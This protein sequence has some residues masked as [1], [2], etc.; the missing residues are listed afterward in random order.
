VRKG[1]RLYWLLLAAPE[2]NL[3]GGWEVDGDEIV[4]AG[5]HFQ[6]GG[7]LR[8]LSWSGLLAGLDGDEAEIVNERIVRCRRDW[9]R[10]KN[11]RM[12]DARPFQRLPSRP[13]K[14]FSQEQWR[15]EQ[16]VVCIGRSDEPLAG[17][18]RRTRS[19]AVFHYS[20]KRDT[21]E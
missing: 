9:K 11:F 7:T 16:K 3:A 20:V 18:A 6:C 8:F 19:T 14:I 12:D 13:L 21:N 2:E 15:K 4:A 5:L 1:D 10:I 17:F